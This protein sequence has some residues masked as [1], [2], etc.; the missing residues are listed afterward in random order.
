MTHSL[1]KYRAL[2]APLLVAAC[3][4]APPAALAP[5]TAAS[6]SPAAAAA[7][8]LASTPAG[9]TAEAS[10]LAGPEVALLRIENPLDRPR[11]SATISIPI[12]DLEKLWLDPTKA[13]I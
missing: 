12:A 9:K 5:E 4:S 10:P 6:P 1:L 11:H 3:V 2:A 8:A 13:V 7:P